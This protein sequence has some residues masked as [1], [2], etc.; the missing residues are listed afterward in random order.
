MSDDVELG[1][2]TIVRTL[3]DDGS[4]VSVQITDDMS[5]YDAMAM[6]AIAQDTVVMMFRGCACGDD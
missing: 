6:M 1:R 4:G 3:D 2:I 5:F